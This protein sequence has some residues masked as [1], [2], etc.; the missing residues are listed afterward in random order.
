M[1]QPSVQSR[2]IRIFISSPGDVAEERA[3]ARMVIKQLQYHPVWEGQ[4]TTESVA[5][6]APG[7]KTPMIATL[8]PQEA[9]NRNLATPSQCDIVIVILWSRLGTPLP[10]EY[11]K[12]DGTPYLSGTEWEYEDAVAAAKLHDGIPIVSIYRRD[13]APEIRLNDPQLNEKQTQWQRVEEFFTQFTNPD[14]SIKGGYNNYSSVEDFQDQLERHLKHFIGQL[15][16]MKGRPAVHESPKWY[17]SPFPGLRPF[18]LDH[19][20]IF[21][22]RHQEIDACLRKIERSTFVAVVGASGAGKSSLV[23][24]GVRHMLKEG[25]VIGSQDWLQVVFTPAQES[26]DPFRGLVAA[27]TPYLKTPVDDLPGQLADEPAHI[28]RII[29]AALTDEPEHVHILL[30]IDQFEEL[31]TLVTP[32]LRA[33]FVEL[34]GHMT[35][36]DCRVH[37]VVTLRADFYPQCVEWS[38]LGSL[39]QQRDG[40]FPLSPPS[41][42]TLL[43]M[44]IHPAHIAG[45]QFEDG[46]AEQIVNDTGESPGALALM[47]YTLDELYRRRTDTNWLTWAAYEAIGG[48]KGAIGSAA[49]AIFATLPPN[50]VACLTTVFRHLIEVDERGTVTRRRSPRDQVAESSDAILLVDALTEGRLLVQNAHLKDGI[51][52]IEVAHEALF[53]SWPRLMEW[54]DIIRDDLTLLK[55]VTLAA[56]DWVARGHDPA[57]FWPAER[58]HMV[59]AAIKRL[60]AE[61]APH[62][63]TFIRPEQE[64]L[65]EQ[66]TEAQTTHQKRLQIGQRLA[67]LGDPRGG[68]GLRA[69]GLPDLIWETVPVGRLKLSDKTSTVEI[70]TFSIARYLI[71]VA[72]FQAFVD[73]IDGY[74][75]E[76]W[77]I[78]LKR[79]A[80]HP[81][82]PA[83]E[84]TNHPRDMVSWV[85]AIAFCRWLT[86][87]TALPAGQVIRLP[88]EW[89]W[90]QAATG[91]QT[92]FTYPWGEFGDLNRMNTAASQLDEV[93]AVGMYPAGSSMVGALDLCGNLAEWCLNGPEDTLPNLSHDTRRI[94]RGGSYADLPIAATTT[95]RDWQDARQRSSTIGFRPV[96]AA[97]LQAQEAEGIVNR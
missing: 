7:I 61:L 84:F 22:G 4:V 48:V 91:G 66:L 40:T 36:T 24:A 67:M 73:A 56:D 34:L 92:N 82:M 15:L 50:A 27:L 65:L 42:F 63:L 18:T 72:Q 37:V 71:T 6:D 57:F 45:L 96:L 87:R 19:A 86:A 43:G 62:V 54:L 25:A 81:A 35:R 79:H 74:Q 2:H 49:E 64:R 85:E 97:P 8:T 76:E 77:W 9:V 70:E 3:I 17:G 46:L 80:A 38:V 83:T 69:D 32:S 53:Q 88:S 75:R 30:L 60:E 58:L 1:P 51:A 28:L 89:E 41:Q 11:V 12:P 29:E 94:V 39:L 59:Y 68:V 90:Q 93:T 10:P 78:D 52:T 13:G 21:W 20:P 23:H 44:I 5:W 95:Y 47:A 31:L 16:T 26:N 55:K 14:R 33:P